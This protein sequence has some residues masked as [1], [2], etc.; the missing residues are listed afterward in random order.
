MKK[1]RWGVIGTGRIARTFC[2]ALQGC[3]DAELYAV[4]SRTP[5]RAAQF[6]AE[7]GFERSYGSYGEIAA[8]DNI[9]CVYIATPMASHFG[10]AMLCIEN[11]RNVLCEKSVTLNSAQLE[12]LLTAAESR[13]VFFMEAMWMKCRPTYLKAMEWLESGRIGRVEY[14]KADFCNFV[15]YDPKDRL[16]APECGGGALLDLTVYPLT[17]VNDIAKTEPDEVVSCAHIGRDGV[18]LSNTLLLRYDGW[19]A[20]LNA[21]FEL[22]NHNNAVIS[23]SGG[24]IVFGDWF[25]CTSEVTLYDRDGKELE[26]SVIPNR[27]NGYEYEIAEVHRCLEAGSKESALVPHSST[28]QVMKIM[29]ECRHQWGMVFPQEK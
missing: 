12:K 23:G 11:G 26:R 20:S 24:S 1:Y 21:G 5:E 17:L 16:F 19:Y 14:V 9:D 13:G 29:D 15:P 2:E 4:G 18:D 3:E 10:D 25:F 27:V 22:Q 6:A 7:F 28:R 8:D